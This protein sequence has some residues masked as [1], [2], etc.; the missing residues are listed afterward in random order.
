[1]PS[2]VATTLSPASFWIMLSGVTIAAFSQLLL[3]TSANRP[4][5]GFWKQYL[6][7]RVITGYV[8][9]LISMLFAVWAYAGMDYKYGPAIESI[10][11]ALVAFLSWWI[12]KE[13]MTFRKVLGIGLIVGGLIV[14]CQ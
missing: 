9:L 3:K 11:F 12:L 5:V 14:F 7:W 10:G 6:N 1:M 2:E 4:H 13:K 8:M